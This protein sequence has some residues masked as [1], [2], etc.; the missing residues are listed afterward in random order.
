VQ[1][2]K[3]GRTA[4]WVVPIVLGLF[5]FAF[6]TLSVVDLANDHYMTLGWAQQ[7]LFGEWPER[8]FVEPGMP[9]SYLPS[10]AIQHLWP[11]PFSEL[12]YTAGMLGLAAAV[13]SVCAAQ[14]GRSW[15]IGIF[16][17]LLELA[18]NPRFHSFPKIL[19][20]A[21]AVLLTQAYARRPSRAGLVAL[22][23]WTAIAF[24]LRHDLGVYIAAAI[25]IGLIV[26]HR[27]SLSDF[28]KAVFAYAA[29]TAALLVPYAVY[30]QWTVGWL[31]HLRR[32]LEFSKSEAHQLFT[33]L[34]NVAAIAQWNRD[35]AVAFLFYAVHALLVVSVLTI[36]LRRHHH[37]R[38]TLAVAATA[39]TALAAFL[40]VILREPIAG[41]LTDLAAV[42]SIVMAWLLGEALA[43]ARSVGRSRPW[44]SGLL[45]TAGVVFAFMSARSV[46]VL[47]NAPEQ[48]DNT[49]IYQ[50]WR[51]LNENW[52]DLKERG[53]VWPW[54]RS[55]PS[56]DFPEAILYLSECT[57]PT[58]AVLLTWPAPEYNFFARRPFGAGHVE[59][60][61]PDAYTT[62]RDQQQMIGRLAH[63]S[64]PVLLTNEDRRAEFTRAYPDVAAYLQNRYRPAGEFTI[65]D[66]SNILVSIRS[67]LQP[68][69]TWGPHDWPCGFR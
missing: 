59:F 3:G 56:R 38:E 50:G 9:L 43:G 49:G 54:A 47:G 1:N 35:G 7:V 27:R 66:G 46:W 12:V 8:D 10:A 67:D 5:A 24:L 58:D 33:G 41:R 13:T 40:P 32:G 55:W 28:A 39:T 42:F 57:S 69:R 48:I 19:T 61:P 2:L 15:V 44:R 22:G 34:P 18:F 68:T 53:S 45:A 21:V 14:L 23:V 60:L 26:L 36:V 30:V 31:E 37:S 62:A 29:G 11:G 16:A 65:Y 17:A 25:A 51:G 6:R 20:P 64:I 52:T 4:V 63:Q